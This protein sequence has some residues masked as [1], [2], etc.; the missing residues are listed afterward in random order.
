MSKRKFN[1]KDIVIH[2]T[3]IGIVGKII[4]YSYLYGE[5]EV[6]WYSNYKNALNGKGL[7]YHRY[8]RASTMELYSNTE[9]PQYE[10]Y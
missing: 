6:K 2:K 8:Q 1:N 9:N 4:N 5:Y 10:I 3:D 7:K